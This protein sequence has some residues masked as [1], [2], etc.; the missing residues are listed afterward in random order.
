MPFEKP[1]KPIPKMICDA[2]EARKQICANKGLLRKLNV[3]GGHAN[4]GELP[5]EA[6]MNTGATG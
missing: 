4:W 3:G 1:T 6:A 2:V 5:I